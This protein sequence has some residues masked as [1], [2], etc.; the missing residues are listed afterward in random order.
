MAN[1]VHPAIAAARRVS[2]MEQE[3]DRHLHAVALNAVLEAMQARGRTRFTATDA[4]MTTVIHQALTNIPESAAADADTH[5]ASPVK[6]V[7][8]EV[9]KS[10]SE[11]IDKLDQQPVEESDKAA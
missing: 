1:E 3:Q 9:V 2:S 8:N 4:R 10:M 7:S 5:V 6:T 11:L